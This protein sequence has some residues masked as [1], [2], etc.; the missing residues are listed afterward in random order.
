MLTKMMASQKTVIQ[1]ATF[2]LV[3]QYCKVI[4]AAVI[5]RGKTVAHWKT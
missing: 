3:V 2:T 4:A 5:S 1:M